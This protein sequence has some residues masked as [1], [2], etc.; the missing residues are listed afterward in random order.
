MAETKSFPSASP[1]RQV[2]YAYRQPAMA[3]ILLNGI[4]SGFP[5]VLFSSALS[6]WLYENNLSRSGVGLFG[7]LG[8]VYALNLLWAPLVDRLRLPW[9]SE[10]FGSR[11]AWILC[12]QGLIL[13][14]LPLFALVDPAQQLLLFAWIAL[15]VALAGA[16][17]DVAIDALRIELAGNDPGGLAAGAGMT[18][19]GWW[20]GYGLGGALVFGLAQQLEPL[21]PQH[22][23]QLSYLCLVAPVLLCMFLLGMARIPATQS[24]MDAVG[25]ESAR[26][27]AV[28]K[29]GWWLELYWGPILSFVHRYGVRLGLILLAVIFLFKSG[30]A[31]LGRMS[32]LFYTDVGFSKA[33][34]AVHAKTFG[35]FTYILCAFLG[36]LLSV[37]Y[38][39]F[40]G[41]VISGLAMA[42]TNLLFV[43]LSHIPSL[44][45]LRFAVIADQ[46]TTAV[47]T[48]A[49][50]AFISQ[51]CVRGHIATHYAALASLGNLSRTT[52]AA[53]SGFVVDGMDGNWS[54]FFILTT[55]MV[56]P[57]LL[58]LLAVRR[59]L[60]RILA[61]ATTRFL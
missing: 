12:M 10:R 35:T 38:G 16:T 29:P 47:S 5:W 25:A 61:G 31:F 1:W 58:L 49:F 40:R 2:L 34:I 19:I 56:L 15:L 48:V 59:H 8:V 4:I 41:L 18:T 11:R 54:L 36:S 23:W 46:F 55:A 39:L 42:G 45:M 9:L 27:P 37:R 20:L 21:F 30:E 57:S 52:L 7:L 6:L 22:Y 60:Q 43:L 50:V 14:S 51:L 24:E 33:E 44:S 26:T 17:Q 13:L 28:A 32:L 53:A 3:L